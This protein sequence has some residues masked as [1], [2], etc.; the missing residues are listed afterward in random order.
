MSASAPTYA[1]VDFSGLHIPM[2]AFE[3]LGYLIVVGISTLAFLAGWLTVNGAVVLT[4]LL[5]A[6]L[7][8][9]SWI[10]L[11]QGRHPA[12]LFLCSLMLFQGGRLIGY[13]LGAESDPMQVV[14][15]T[16]APFQ[17]P[18]EIAGLVLLALA[19]SAICIYAPCRWMYRPIA[20]PS[21]VTVTKCL[22]YLYLL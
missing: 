10:H 21:D 2:A 16:P 20:P 3:V 18:R 9:L 7:I 8:V 5:L 14:I 22:P 11:G 15:M 13:C 6:A 17:V 12:F 4:V 19:L 1:G